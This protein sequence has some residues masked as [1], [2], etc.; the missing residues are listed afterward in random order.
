LKRE[1]DA[2]GGD[3]VVV[4][5]G[6]VALAFPSSEP[7][8]LSFDSPLIDHGQLRQWALSEGWL[9]R[10]APE[11]AAEESNGNPPVRFTKQPRGH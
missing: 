4:P 6:Q 11:M 3:D 2:H 9:V 8:P 1:L 10:P 7:N 5:Y